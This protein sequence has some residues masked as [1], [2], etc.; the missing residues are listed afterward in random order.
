MSKKL[1]RDALLAD[2]S[3]VNKMLDRMPDSDLM[4]RS[5][6]VARRDELQ[7]AL[8]EIENFSDTLANVALFFNGEP[9]DG[10]RSI[11]AEFAS[12][13]LNAFQEI[14]SKKLSSNETGGLAQVGRLPV[15]EAARL[16][17]TNIVHGSFG[18]VLEESDQD[19]PQL[20]NSSLKDTVDKVAVMIADITDQDEDKF[21]KVIDSIEP[22]I[23]GSVRNFFKTVFEGGALLRIVEDERDL[24]LDR[25]T[26]KR[27]YDRIEASDVQ[28]SEKLL[29]GSLIG[30]T[31]I[32]KRF[33]FR[34]SETGEVIKGTIGPMLGASFLKRIENDEKLLGKDWVAVIKRKTV[35]KPDGRVTTTYQML[36]LKDP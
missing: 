1:E 20:V 34:S 36:D 23:F 33:E 12:K 7:D 30:L 4:G 16:N 8:N 3:A 27:G 24:R 2:L 21:S 17:I 35:H 19:S 26:L 11:D 22:R 10:S 15:K 14:I 6:F 13:A 9:V 32:S 31:P 29:S 28:E 18:F 25:I 5:S